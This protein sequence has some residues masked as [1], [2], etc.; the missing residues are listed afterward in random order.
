MSKEVAELS[1]YLIIL[2][3]LKHST[4][5]LMPTRTSADLRHKAIK[6]ALSR[7][8][9]KRQ[10]VPMS[11]STIPF[12]K[13]K[14]YSP[15]VAVLL[16]AM[17]QTSCRNNAVNPPEPYGACPTEQQVE[18]QRMEMN[19]FCH[20]GP[21]TFT[22]KEWGDGTEAESLFNPSALDCRQWVDVALNA[23]MK[24]IIL[25]AKHHDGFCLWPS[26]QSIHTVALSPW[27]DG[28]GDILKELQDACT[29][30]I[31]MGVYISPWDRN[32]PAYGTDAYNTV[33]ASTLYEVHRNYGPLFE[34]WFDGA[35]G[36]G[37]KGKRQ[38]YDWQLF[39]ST[40]LTINP[41]AVIF[42]DVGPGCRW[43]GNEDGSA[44]ETCWSTLN[45]DG[46]TPGAGSP[47]TDRL[48]EGDKRGTYWIPA[49]TDVSI[50]KGWFWHA[51]EHPKS[52]EEL[53]DIYYKSVGRN[54]LL[55]L[56]VP[57]DERGLIPA[58]DSLRLTELRK[59]LDNI[60]GNDLAK[61]AKVSASNVRGGKHNRTFSAD[62]VI[63]TN[64]DSY[65]SVD[66]SVTSPTLTLKF[67]HSTT[68][69]RILLQEY[70]PLGQRVAA[71]HV[72]YLNDDGK[73]ETL[74][75]ATTIGYKRILIIPETTTKGLRIVIDEALACPTINR[76][77]L[78]IDYLSTTEN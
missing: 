46:Y 50:R 28:Q 69:N 13:T 64:Y 57:P 70:I 5:R 9:Y 21:N 38:D 8:I 47:G 2:L 60:F 25:T 61:D 59:V 24:G 17:I 63:D 27:R 73:W 78:F 16:L 58:E 35:N 15:L 55:L 22:D 37:P 51:E 71:F 49:E 3:F 39:N 68:F 7:F 11:I 36:E 52:V 41:Q 77:G 53:L 12:R 4:R 10:Q 6:S 19:M 67:K 14:S 75:Q 72:E 76:V 54:S 66:D 45:T 29:G 34:Q 65:W 40:V 33:F 32:H 62:N 18:W 74:T 1:F 23:G 43:V 26:S 44:G 48:N 42:S 31:K 30:K 20:F 56:N